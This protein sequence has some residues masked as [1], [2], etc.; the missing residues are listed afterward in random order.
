MLITATT[1][2]SNLYKLLDDVLETGVPIKIKK[3][4]RILEVYAKDKPGKL[5]R[6]TKHK[7][8]NVSPESIVHIDWSKEW[9]NDLP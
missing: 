5:D 6:L 1:F 9:N 8:L 2:R 3:N 7:S 4:N